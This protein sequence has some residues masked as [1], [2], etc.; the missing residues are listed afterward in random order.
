MQNAVAVWVKLAELVGKGCY[1]RVPL[2]VPSF[3]SEILRASLPELSLSDLMK[4]ELHLVA[5]AGIQPTAAKEQAALKQAP[6][7]SSTPV[8]ADYEGAFFL[9]T[10]PAAEGVYAKAPSRAPSRVTSDAS[11]IFAGSFRLDWLLE[12]LGQVWLLVGG[13]D[14]REHPWKH[15]LPLP[16]CVADGHSA[17]AEDPLAYESFELRER[18]ADIQVDRP[19]ERCDLPTPSTRPGPGET[20]LDSCVAALSALLPRYA[21]G[22][23]KEHIT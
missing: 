17:V 5:R 16:P 10:R 19:A 22:V 12:G 7:I 1:I 18:S 21:S 4:S 14:D 23:M 3:G 20:V 15:H 8:G 11:A 2:G 9:V 6:F 13:Q